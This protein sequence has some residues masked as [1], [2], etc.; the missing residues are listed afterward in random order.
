MCAHMGYDRV[1]PQIWQIFYWHM[2]ENILTWL[3]AYKLCLQAKTGVGAAKLPLQTDILIIQ[4]Y[5]PKWV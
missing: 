4:D 1:Y 5:F 2:S 3:K